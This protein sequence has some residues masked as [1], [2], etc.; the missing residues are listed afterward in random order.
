MS[1]QQDVNELLRQG[2]EAAK[3]GNR[4][5]AR[6]IL[7]RVVEL[8]PQNEKGWLWLASVYEDR[9]R[10]AALKRVLEINPENAS[11]QRALAKMAPE[12]PEEALRD[13]VM[14]GVDKRTFT[15]AIAV[16][17]IALALVLLVF[18][19]ITINNNNAAAAA[20]ATQNAIFMAQ[21]AAV[22]Q[23]NT[24]VAIVQA[25]ASAVK[26]PTP[27]PTR[28]LI[29]TWTPTDTP[30]PLGVAPTPLATPENLPGTIIGWSGRDLQNIGYFPVGYYNLATGQFTASGGSVGRDASGHPNGQQIVYARYDQL[31]FDT[32][33][34]LINLNG[35]SP[36]SLGDRWGNTAG[37]ISPQMPDLSPDGNR[38]VFIAEDPQTQT[39]AQS[40]FLFDLSSNTLRKLT[41]DEAFYSDPAISPDGRQVAVVRDDRNG[42]TPG[43]DIVI[44]D[45]ES[46]TQTALTTDLTSFTE[47]DPVWSPDGANIAYAAAPAND[48]G[49]ADIAIRASG[50]FGLPT[51]PV[52]HEA[53]DMMP[54]YS[55][56]GR[57]LAFTS[58]RSGQ[59]DIFVF[60]FTTDTLTQL[61]N[62]PEQDYTG[63]WVQAGA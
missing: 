26:S 51:L 37:A 4:D 62:T 19:I 45:I 46:G 47:S 57:Y 50:G 14:P 49:N 13:E 21:T 33:I 56:D 5:E 39:Q 54:V 42:A 63:D 10:R 17:G 35:T 24:E 7:E 30:P 9:E 41:N 3:L 48:P 2:I 34:E 11:A 29:P 55:P 18:I 44:I 59:L 28:T 58:D 22:D 20:A 25:T 61:T 31:L 8:D 60:D 6:Q 27:A 53:N 15:I 12:A 40:V 23:A 36:E 1:E 32:L 16:G 52:R 43:A 38:L